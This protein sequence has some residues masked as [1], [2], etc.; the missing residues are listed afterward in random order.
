MN[1]RYAETGR[2]NGSAGMPVDVDG[3]GWLKLTVLLCVCSDEK[4]SCVP[5]AEDNVGV[6]VVDGFE[7]G[8]SLPCIGE[9]EISFCCSMISR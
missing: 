1:E 4:E 5:E 7:I 2:A 6:V 3:A 8:C 9:N